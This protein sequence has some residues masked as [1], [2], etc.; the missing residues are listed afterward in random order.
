MWGNFLLLLKLVRFEGLLWWSSSRHN[1]TIKKLCGSFSNWLL[2][3]TSWKIE[4]MKILQLK[5]KLNWNRHFWS[6]DTVFS[7]SPCI[8]GHLIKKFGL[9]SNS[10]ATFDFDKRFQAVMPKY[11]YCEKGLTNIYCFWFQLNLSGFH[12]FQY[13]RK[14][15]LFASASNADLNSITS[16]IQLA[17]V[18]IKTRHIFAFR[19]IFTTLIFELLSFSDV[20]LVLISAARFSPVFQLYHLNQ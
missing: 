3:W 17:P 11:W 15:N 14:W 7:G 6:T 10:F 5:I 9:D 19:L 1:G 16:Q 4:R 20:G 13:E 8:S 12:G 2:D 18:L